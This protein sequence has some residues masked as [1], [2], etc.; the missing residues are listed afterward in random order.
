M[1]QRFSLGMKIAAGFA[2]ALLILGTVGL[3]SYLSMKRLLGSAQWE[4][5]THEVL[6]KLEHVLSL[7]KDI[8]NGART[9]VLTGSDLYLIH[10][11]LAV[12]DIEQD[13]T[14]LRVLT[15]DNPAQQRRLDRLEHL[16]AEKLARSRGLIKNRKDK[17]F[18]SATLVPLSSRGNDVMDEIRKSVAA[19]QDEEHVLLSRRTIETKTSARSATAVIL[20]GSVLAL[21]FVGLASVLISRDMAWRKKAEKQLEENH[22]K[23]TGWVTE[24]EREAQEHTILSELG[25]L[26]Q[27]CLTT[28]EAHIVIAKGMRD[29]FP[30]TSGALY[31]IDGS[32]QGVEV[33]ALWDK[34]AALQRAFQL[35]ECWALRRGQMHVV[36]DPAAGPLCRH[37]DSSSPSSYFCLPLMAQGEMMG[38][39]HVRCLLPDPVDSDNQPGFPSDSDRR[40]AVIVGEHI[41]LALANLRLRD[42]LRSQS[43]RDPLTGVF[44]R[45]YMEESLDRELHRA[46]RNNTP[47][48]VVMV[49]LDHFKQFNDTFGHA[50]GD[51]LLTKVGDFLRTQIRAEDIACRYGGEEFV[52][53]LPGSSLEA[54]RMRAE[55]VREDLRQVQVEHGGRFLG[56]IT[57]SA[58]VATFP[59]DGI[60]AKA[61]LQAADEAL[62]QA[63]S[64]GRNRVATYQSLSEHSE[65]D[66]P[67]SHRG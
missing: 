56:M 10:Y 15:S 3:T 9:F 46:S 47:L 36:H 25:D 1:V 29:L 65:R 45:R 17:R 41:S 24:L 62:Y 21:M 27:T 14:A 40:L 57:L 38:L 51:T 28:N 50:A 18:Q 7:T 23:L 59:H 43:I 66:L 60:T 32:R 64:A 42:A 31:L 53:I 6:E 54:T 16:V 4:S 48:G 26:L 55:Q 35:D 61:V 44:N 39:L 34:H 5:H 2:A 58:G 11:D 30:R 37:F 63:K 22:Q 19:M 49:D 12:N 52:L 13:M 67:T 33:M 20:I 8:E